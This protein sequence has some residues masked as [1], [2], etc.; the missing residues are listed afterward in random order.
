VDAVLDDSPPGE[1]SPGE[2]PPLGVVTPPSPGELVVPLGSSVGL[3]GS[4]VVVVVV[5]VEVEVVS[6]VRASILSRASWRSF[7]RSA[8]WTASTMVATQNAVEAKPK[9][10]ATDLTV[11]PVIKFYYFKLHKVFFYKTHR[12]PFLGIILSHGELLTA[13]TRLDAKLETECKSRI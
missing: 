10:M 11:S 8:F 6:A 13:S 3:L 5:E 2:V 4:A 12:Q 7:S 1:V 9:K